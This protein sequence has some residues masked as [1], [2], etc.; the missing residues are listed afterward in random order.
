[1][2][3]TERLFALIDILRTCKRPITSDRLATELSVS[4][5]SIYRDI[6]ALRAMGAPIDGEAGVGYRLRAGFLLP[7]LMLTADEL[8]ALTLGGSWVRQRADPALS[9]A[10]SSALAKIAAVLP[11]TFA[12]PDDVPSLVTAAPAEVPAD[13]ASTS[14]LRDA[15]RRQHKVAVRYTDAHEQD[16]DRI[17]WPIAIAYFDQAR[18]LAAWCESRAA[19]RHFRIDRFQRTKILGERYPEPRGRLL[20]RWREQ[21]P[22]TGL[23]S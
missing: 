5:R 23:R 19:F 2:T 11:G 22:M 13:P 18:I 12:P 16:S 21:D 1:M 20:R 7:P 6:D 8:D 15:I 17:L 3:R 4:P 9:A 14:V 10:A